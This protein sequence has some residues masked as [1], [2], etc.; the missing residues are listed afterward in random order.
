M[1]SKQMCSYYAKLSELIFFIGNKYFKSASEYKLVF[2][3]T[4]LQLYPS[5]SLFQK[6]ILYSNSSVNNLRGFP[7]T[8][9]L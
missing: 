9:W 2:Q 5:Q 6:D 3:Q 8:F 4:F 7:K 1:N